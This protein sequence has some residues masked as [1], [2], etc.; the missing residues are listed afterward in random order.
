MQVITT[1]LAVFERTL[2]TLLASL[3]YKRPPV[4]K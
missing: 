3:Q 2:H 4:A 1:A